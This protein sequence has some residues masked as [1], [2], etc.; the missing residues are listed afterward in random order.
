MKPVGGA[1]AGG[2]G[3]PSQLG[4]PVRAVSLAFQ[5]WVALA[6]DAS[7]PMSASWGCTLC[8]LSASHC[9]PHPSPTISPVVSTC[10]VS[11][12]TGRS[13]GSHPLGPWEPSRPVGW[14]WRP[15][16]RRGEPAAPASVRSGRREAR[17]GLGEARAVGGLT[18]PACPSPHGRCPSF[19][20]MGICFVGKRS[21]ENFI[22]QVSVLCCGW[23]GPCLP[24]RGPAVTKRLSP[25]FTAAAW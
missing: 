17:G 13:R 4:D 23:K 2:G 19:Q 21:F 11:G 8:L 20:S 1:R 14:G 3:D 9:S 6:M 18:P 22:L 15:G 25:V 7:D 5:G 12:V 16:A 10:S 24:G